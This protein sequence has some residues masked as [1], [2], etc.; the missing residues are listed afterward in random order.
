MLSVCIF[1]VLFSVH[2]TAMCGFE[3]VAQLVELAKRLP[4]M[5]EVLGP[6]NR[7]MQAGCD[8]TSIT[9]ALWG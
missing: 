6:G 5:Q 4:S 7:V 9:P 3:V 2:S 8:Y 1:D